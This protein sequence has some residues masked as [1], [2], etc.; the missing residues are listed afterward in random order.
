[1]A[2]K[3][4]GPKGQAPKSQGG[5]APATAASSSSKA[6]P[7][8]IPATA[9][10]PHIDKTPVTVHT[11]VHTEV[12]ASAH[13]TEPVVV[14]APKAKTPKKAAADGH[15]ATPHK[16]EQPA[17][18]ATPAVAQEPQHLK[19]D[20]ALSHKT[21][22]RDA[23]AIGHKEQRALV[24]AAS[25]PRCNGV[26]VMVAR[27]LERRPPHLS[28]TALTIC[29]DAPSEYH[30]S[31][32]V[33]LKGAHVNG[34]CLGNPLFLIG[35]TWQL[36]FLFWRLR[37]DIVYVHSVDIYCIP[38]LVLS[39]LFRARSVF[40]YHTEI[41][42]FLNFYGLSPRVLQAIKAYYAILLY[43]CCKLAEQVVSPSEGSLKYL[44]DSFSVHRRKL[45]KWP[46]FVDTQ[47]FH[48]VPRDAAVRA[49]FCPP[50][51]ALILFCGRIAPEKKIEDSLEMISRH[52]EDFH[53]AIVGPAS[54]PKYMDMLKHKYGGLFTWADALPQRELVSI[55]AA[56]DLV[57]NACPADTFGLSIMEAVA[58]G[59]PVLAAVSDGS[60]EILT[61]ERKIGHI[62][63]SIEEGIKFLVEWRRSAAIQKELIAN[64]KTFAEVWSI[65]PYLQ[66]MWKFAPAP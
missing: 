39:R 34:A 55:Y 47:V 14:D 28:M 51:K 6:T 44:E 63:S 48:P 20:V 35:V 57:I 21:H 3:G 5:T 49:R 4:K 29:Q 31:P 24:F 33:S 27:K 46:Y 40:C 36:F 19:P 22:H 61:P 25:F 37:P 59:V 56:A 7:A 32:V 9:E 11:N 15:H 41:L 50:N 16:T 26:N 38:L 52:P 42:T 64:C 66:F 54:N 17:S 53:M 62:Y 23:K 30:G 58:C 13:T 18:I 45:S 60:R 1:M 8:A 2:K 65:E 10:E 12:D 43:A